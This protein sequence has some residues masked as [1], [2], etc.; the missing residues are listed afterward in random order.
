MC[1][2]RKVIEPVKHTTFRIFWSICY[3]VPPITDRKLSLFY[4]I[5]DSKRT[6]I[7]FH[8][9]NN[10]IHIE[11]ICQNV[12]YLTHKHFVCLKWNNKYSILK[13]CDVQK[14]IFNFHHQFFCYKS[15]KKSR[16]IAEESGLLYKYVSATHYNSKLIIFVRLSHQIWASTW[17]Y[18]SRLPWIFC[19]TS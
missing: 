16:R 18:Q 14:P 2:V 6:Y 8:P 3:N 13:G 5:F 12:S 1:Y 10:L 15:W 11:L 17:D 4:R 9:N 19:G 7:C